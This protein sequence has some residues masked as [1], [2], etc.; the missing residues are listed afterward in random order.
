M[1]RP[2]WRDRRPRAPRHGQT[3]ARE[4]GHA[5]AGRTEAHDSDDDLRDP[6]HASGCGGQ[7]RQAG[8]EA[9]RAQHC[10][11]EAGTDGGRPCASATC[12]SS[13]S[14]QVRRDAER[15]SPLRHRAEAP[16]SRS[17]ERYRRP[18]TRCAAAGP[19]ARGIPGTGRASSG[20]NVPSA[21]GCVRHI[22]PGCDPQACG[23]NP[24][25]SAQA[26]GP[27]EP[28]RRAQPCD[29]TAR[30][31]TSPTSGS[32]AVHA[33]IGGLRLCPA[34]AFAHAAAAPPAP[35]A[36]T[37]SAD[38]TCAG[39]CRCAGSSAT[40]GRGGGGRNPGWV[41]VSPPRRDD[42]G[43]R[44]PGFRAGTSHAGGA[45]R[46]CRSR[47]GARYPSRPS[48]RTGSAGRLLAQPCGCIRASRRTG[49]GHAP[50]RTHRH[51][52][53]HARAPA[54][55]VAGSHRRRFHRRHRPAAGDDH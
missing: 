21:P 45:R 29:A 48:A 16:R 49:R 27:I 53:R 42:R 40:P 38:G 19:Q 6:G 43:R 41:P 52:S 4:A 17:N 33:C 20:R 31:R 7:R 32:S 3:G 24:A 2:A 36:G 51:L 46:P 34:R 12:R 1:G 11:T 5:Q 39:S 23:S 14:A 18:E 37:D 9:C 55:A 15:G 35:A 8:A 26:R 50:D 13:H 47:T 54:P 28:R 10:R 30:A 25:S 22:R 44:A